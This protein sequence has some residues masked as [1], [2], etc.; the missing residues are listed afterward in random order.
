MFFAWSNKFSLG[1]E[2]WGSESLGPWPQFTLV[3]WGNQNLN[4]GLPHS[5]AVLTMLFCQKDE[6]PVFV[7]KDNRVG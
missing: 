4:K 7:L 3:K 6:K 1:G 2:N 5:K